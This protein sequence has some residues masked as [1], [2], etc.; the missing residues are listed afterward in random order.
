MS[1]SLKRNAWQYGK[2]IC[3][4]DDAFGAMTGDHLHISV[5]FKVSKIMVP[6]YY[7]KD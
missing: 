5:K 3:S 7:G 1:I 4:F 2:I 6:E